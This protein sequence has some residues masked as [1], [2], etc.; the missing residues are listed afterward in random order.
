MKNISRY[1]LN[2]PITMLILAIVTITL[3]CTLAIVRVI[4]YETD[5]ATPAPLYHYENHNGKLYA[6]PTGLHIFHN[7]NGPPQLVKD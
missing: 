7:D 2:L 6:I 1:T 3:L 5:Q 4:K